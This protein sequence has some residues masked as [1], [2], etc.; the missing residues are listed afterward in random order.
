[1]AWLRRAVAAG[2]RDKD[3]LVKRKE[4]DVLR[5]RGDFRERIAALEA[6]PE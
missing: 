4:F 2:F 1:M 3:G 5:D 6:E